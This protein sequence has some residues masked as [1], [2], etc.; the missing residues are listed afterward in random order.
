MCA[1][2]ISVQREVVAQVLRRVA[3]REMFTAWDVRLGVEDWAKA[4]AGGEPV[5]HYVVRQM[6]HALFFHDAMGQN[7]V[8]TT[9]P[10]G[11]TGE[12]AFVYH[13]IC[14]APGLYLAAQNA[15]QMLSP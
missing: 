9:A 11:R 2:S 13:H 1:L 3:R 7:Y 6:V 12:T 10:V 8:R 4:N 5:P 14:D 15:A